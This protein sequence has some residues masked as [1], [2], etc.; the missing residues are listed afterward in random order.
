MAR[1]TALAPVTQVLGHVVMRQIQTALE[2]QTVSAVR[3]SQALLISALAIG[4]AE[5]TQIVPVKAAI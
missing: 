1:I 4:R 3:I 5:T 2:R